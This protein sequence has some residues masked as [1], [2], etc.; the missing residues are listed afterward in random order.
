MY[1]VSTL[2]SQ[3]IYLLSNKVITY[4][5]KYKVYIL[6]NLLRTILLDLVKSICK[7]NQVTERINMR[8]IL[9]IYYT[10]FA[11]YLHTYF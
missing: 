4:T 1:I 5:P 6:K 11:T 3:Y 2:A 8:S 10:T 9:H 7:Y